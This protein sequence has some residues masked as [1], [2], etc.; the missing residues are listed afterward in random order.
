M[1]QLLSF[2]IIFVFLF[3]AGVKAE[4]QLLTGRPLVTTL[5][6]RGYFCS[7]QRAN[8]LSTLVGTFS[9][10]DINDIQ[11]I[12]SDEELDEWVRCYT[13]D[14]GYKNFQSAKTLLK[15]A[16]KEFGVPY[17]LM[18]CKIW[19][20][21]HWQN[22][23]V[24][25]DNARGI[26]QI[27]PPQVATLKN[28][29][30]LVINPPPEVEDYIDLNKNYNHAY[31]EKK[32]LEDNKSRSKDQEEAL[33]SWTKKHLA[34]AKQIKASREKE[35]IKNYDLGVVMNSAWRDWAAKN[36][37]NSDICSSN[38]CNSASDLNNFNNIKWA[39][40]AGALNAMY[41][42]L[43]L[44]DDF[45]R[46]PANEGEKMT[47]SREEFNLI[48][49]TAYNSGQSGPVQELK[50]VREEDQGEVR[51]AKLLKSLQQRGGAGMR[52]WGQTACYVSNIDACLRPSNMK[53][54]T[55]ERPS[56]EG[57]MCGKSDGN[58]NLI[59]CK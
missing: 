25:V 3:V 52:G 37:L 49:A 9:R 24:S 2:F 10:E 28:I 45:S 26:V 30:A 58:K 14:S 41:L 44:D 19:Q 54:V 47:Y 5:T 36:N 46:K 17:G 39:V 53:P 55:S 59:D 4:A 56:Q 1:K 38:G 13:T 35:I 11:S 22:G 16:E 8:L 50:P 48:M 29:M 6:E 15:N 21:T 23:K 42:M 32:K 20:E 12:K 18:T 27:I 31:D 40:G 34:L 57:P 7:G 43:K 33:Q 51:I